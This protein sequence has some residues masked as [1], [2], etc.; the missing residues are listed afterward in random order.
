MESSVDGVYGLFTGTTP[1]SK[2]AAVATARRATAAMI[3]RQTF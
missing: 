2:K 1:R 3:A